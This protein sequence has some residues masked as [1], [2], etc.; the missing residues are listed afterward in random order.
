MKTLTLDL[1]TIDEIISE[2]TLQ[3]IEFP[4][5]NVLADL[6][7]GNAERAV[8]P[9]SIK[10]INNDAG[11]F[12]HHIKSNEKPRYLVIDSQQS[13]IFD[14]LPPAEILYVFQKLLRFC[15]K[16]W[17]GLS[18]TY[19][20]RVITG[21]SK[22]IL[23]PFQFRPDP[24]RVV[25]E[26]EPMAERLEKRGRAG[27]FLL[28]YKAGFD[29]GAP[30]EEPSFANFKRVYEGLPRVIDAVRSE[31]DTRPA[32]N[33][34]D[35]DQLQV[36]RLTGL[37]NGTAT[38]MFRSYDDWLPLLTDSQRRF[39]TAPIVGSFRIEGPAGTGKTLSL[40]L[41]ALF[42]LNQAAG[43]Q[44]DFHAAFLTHS[45]ATRDTIRETVQVMDQRGFGEQS[46]SSSGQS[47]SILTLSDLCSQQLRQSI[48]ETEFL[49]RDAMESKGLQLLHINEAIDQATLKIDSYAKIMSSKFLSFVKNE[50]RWTFSELMQHEI[51]V[52]IKGRASEHFD[53]YKSI[54]SLK[55]GLPVE[56]DGDKSFV[57]GVFKNYQDRL[58]ATGQFDTDDVVITTIGQLDTP[59][60]RRRRSRQGYHAIFVDETH[61][62]NIN[63]LHVFHHFT[64]SE[65]PY[66]I[67]YSI[68][69]SQAVGDRGWTNEQIAESVIPGDQQSDGNSAIKTVFRSSPEIVNLAF[70]V[71]SSAATLFENFDNPLDMASS[72]F[73]ADEEALSRRPTYLE[74]GS[75]QDMI[76]GA[77]SIAE[78][79]V[80]DMGCRRS[81]LLIV[82]LD[83][84]LLDQLRKYTEEKN[85][86][87]SILTRRGDLQAVEQARKSGH[88]VL[89][90]S[91]YVGGLEFFGVVIVGVDEGRVPY[92]SPNDSE[93][94]KRYLSYISH[95]RLYVA[96]TRAKY[97]VAVLGEQS[98]GP[99][100]LIEPAIYAGVLEREPN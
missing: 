2:R 82:C 41:K 57:Y 60:W 63:E 15:K 29:K 18:L 92:K 14:Q 77:F 99:S 9:N 13:G 97:R 86:P 23:F 48:A 90:H 49:D 96:I 42:N 75:E 64:R 85:K 28:V 81:D 95:N 61:L 11:T 26:R 40:I 10:Q 69:R 55:Y 44:R 8:L 94:S 72:G 3:S 50:D 80:S 76:A 54:P 78:S 65:G 98:R 4:D 91:D 100:K 36:A 70:S 39:V 22:A 5:G 35:I 38:S 87:I 71:V 19:S 68:D 43:E 46:P 93:S 16:L 52:I 37:G 74:Y 30:S 47:L 79:F 45:A 89:G 7:C 51:S 83:D 67:V 27:T 62:F 33:L 6:L 53:T 56:N 21:S 88:F 31:R 32:E 12:W 84:A 73:T 34:A 1:A 24:Y 59:I 25:I 66:P 58:R 17:T 20:E